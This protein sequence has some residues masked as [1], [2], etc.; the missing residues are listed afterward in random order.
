M[1]FHSWLLFLIAFFAVAL[2]PGPNVLLVVKSAIKH[3]YKV[4]GII[5]VVNLFCQLLIVIAVA[6]GAGALL[7]KSPMLF[8]I[9]K[10]VGG[11]YLIYLGILG[12]FK[13]TS[14]GQS[15]EVE[16]DEPKQVNYLKISKEAFLVSASNPK[17]VIFLSA[18]LPQ[19]ISTDSPIAMQFSI[20]FMTIC[21]IVVSIH[22]AYSY[23]AR[24]INK[25]WSGL[26]VKTI[27]SK[28]TNSAFVAFGCG[29]LLSSRTT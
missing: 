21:F 13:G 10:V 20:M 15:Q 22:M 16:Y 2:A 9:L 12:L 17:T 18:F 8:L 3:G 14:S 7:V 29:V 24:N 6:F 1:D 11:V 23:I 4:A 27:F 25:K 26:K 5:I 19:F 28:I